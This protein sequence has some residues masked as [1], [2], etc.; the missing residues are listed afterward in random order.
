MNAFGIP[1]LDLQGEYNLVRPWVYQHFNLAGNYTQY[2]Q[3]LGH[4]WGSNVRE[5]TLQ[6]SYHPLASLHL[7]AQYGQAVKGE[8]FNGSDLT[9]P[10]IA[11][12]TQY[13][14]KAGE[15]PVLHTA[16]MLYLRASWQVLQTDIYLEAEARIRREWVGSTDYSGTSAL[17]GLRFGIPSRPMKF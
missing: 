2:G 15:G 14:Y 6:A 4:S 8:G 16:K 9:Q 17:A 10:Y 13:G 3:V 1:T 7:H 5:W 11:P 12:A